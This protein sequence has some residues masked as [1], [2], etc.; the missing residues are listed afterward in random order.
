MQ[1][2]VAAFR[3]RIG[4]SYEQL[5]AAGGGF[6]RLLDMLQEAGRVR[7]AIRESRKARAPLPGLP[8][9]PG[10]CP[11]ACR[12]SLHLAPACGAP[13]CGAPACSASIPCQEWNQLSMGRM[14]TAT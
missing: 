13:A 9:L 14:A 2:S 10:C 5:A 1:A 4:Q 6:L 12:P 7:A 3:S 11:D 8:G